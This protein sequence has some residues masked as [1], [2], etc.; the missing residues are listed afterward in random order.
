MWGPD[1]KFS[2]IPQTTAHQDTNA[3]YALKSRGFGGEIELVAKRT[4]VSVGK[5]HAVA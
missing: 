5:V 1:E 3:L 4:G 2:E